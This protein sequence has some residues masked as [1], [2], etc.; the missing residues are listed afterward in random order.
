MWWHSLF[1]HVECDTGCSQEDY[2]EHLSTCQETRDTAGNWKGQNR[3][4][5]I[6]MSRFL[7][8]WG[9]AV[10][11]YIHTYMYICCCLVVYSYHSLYASSLGTWSFMYVCLHMN[12]MCIAHCL[13]EVGDCLDKQDLTDQICLLYF[14]LLE[15][16]WDHWSLLT[17]LY[18]AFH[19]NFELLAPNE[20]KK[21]H[22]YSWAYSQG[23]PGC[24]QPWE[25]GWWVEESF[26]CSLATFPPCTYIQADDV[27]IQYRAISIAMQLLLKGS[28]FICI[29]PHM[30]HLTGVLC[31]I[32]GEHMF[33]V[34]AKQKSLLAVIQP[35]IDSLAIQLMCIAS[36][37]SIVWWP[38]CPLLFWKPT[39]R[40]CRL[41][42]VCT[43]YSLLVC[44]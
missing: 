18:S 39:Y 21:L 7:R 38:Y 16:N 13:L 44:Y 5:Y 24:P 9:S 43:H 41:I 15:A 20:A 11:V 2:S 25:L 3:Y 22:V 42:N 1:T 35:P 12:Y 33:N 37:N 14:E 10:E 31:C 19:L 6:Y 23:T 40:G 29:K 28:V 30:V 27:R 36:S 32:R 26:T 8:S 4:V 17:C 34:K